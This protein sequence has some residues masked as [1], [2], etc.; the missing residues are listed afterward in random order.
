M[1]R[2][3]MSK[4]GASGSL[5]AYHAGLVLDGARDAIGDLDSGCPL[6]VEAG[7]GAA[8]RRL[9]TYAASRDGPRFACCNTGTSASDSRSS[10]RKGR[11]RLSGTG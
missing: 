5:Q 7:Y 10:M 8:L 3:A 6:L 1:P 9:T 11:G 4:I 2:C